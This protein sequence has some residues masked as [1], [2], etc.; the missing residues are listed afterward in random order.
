MR[1]QARREL[2]A[3]L[4]VD[5]VGS[6]TIVLGFVSDAGV[7][8]DRAEVAIPV[9]ED[10]VAACRFSTGGDQVVD[11]AAAMSAGSRVR[12]LAEQGERALKLAFADRQPV[13]VR[14]RTQVAISS[15]PRR[16]AR[17]GGKW[18]CGQ[19]LAPIQIDEA[20]R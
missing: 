2:L 12:E 9:P 8:T 11:R 19:R 16:S 3:G 1:S 6:R 14:P 18:L 10:N 13:Q 15:A 17:S 20:V 7:V 5:S 4:D